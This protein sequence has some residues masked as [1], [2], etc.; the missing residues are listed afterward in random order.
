M[1]SNKR[2]K[3]IGFTLLELMVT[4]AMLAALTASC[5]VLMRTSYTAWNRHEDDHSQRESG[6]AV[7]RHI[8]RQARQMRSVMAIS[9]PADN[10]GSLSLLSTDGRLL[11]WEHNSGTKQILFGENTA[12]NVL[13]TGIEELTFVGKN[14]NDVTVTAPGLIHSIDCTT[15]VNIT[16]PSG[17]E[18]ITSSCRA[19]L[20]AW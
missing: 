10:S 5:M 9:A 11:V 8:T 6:I 7:L 13:A 1:K 2:H 15:K 19:W 12:T 18:T 3:R 16:K 14:I 20:R 4:T 17:T